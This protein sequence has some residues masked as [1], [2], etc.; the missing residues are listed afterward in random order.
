MENISR[1]S[2]SIEQLWLLSPVIS[3]GFTDGVK[4]QHRKLS[5]WINMLIAS[6]FV[7]EKLD[8][9]GPSAARKPLI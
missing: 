7:I 5:S 1:V 9:W 3:N 2:F 4:K 6:G 8:E